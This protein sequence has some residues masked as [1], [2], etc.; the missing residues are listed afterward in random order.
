MPV[1][2]SDLPVRGAF[3]KQAAMAQLF[4]RKF[5]PYPFESY[6][7]VV[8]DDELEIPLEARG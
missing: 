8:V 6:K 4:E 1:P 5:G 7:I 3:A 2:G